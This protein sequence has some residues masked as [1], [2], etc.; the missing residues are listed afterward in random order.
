MPQ[1]FGFFCKPSLEHFNFIFQLTIASGVGEVIGRWQVDPVFDDDVND[2]FDVVGKT[3]STLLAVP[4]SGQLR[5][6]SVDV[7]RK[8]LDVFVACR[9]PELLYVFKRQVAASVD[10]VIKDLGCE[11]AIKDSARDLK[12]RLAEIKDPDEDDI[13]MAE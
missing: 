9:R 13:E 1:P 3:L 7:S 12:R 4:K 2:I 11:A 10:D 6:K 8:V 5:L